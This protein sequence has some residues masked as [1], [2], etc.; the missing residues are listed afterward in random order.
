MMRVGVLQQTYSPHKVVKAQAPVQTSR[1]DWPVG[2]LF[3]QDPQRVTALLGCVMHDR[4][5]IIHKIGTDTPFMDQYQ[6]NTQ[7]LRHHIVENSEYI[8][9]QFMSQGVAEDSRSRFIH[10]ICDTAHTYQGR[11]GDEYSTLFAAANYLLEKK[12]SRLATDSRANMRYF[13]NP[14]KAQYPI[15][16]IYGKTA[17]SA[18]A[19]PALVSETFGNILFR[20]TPTDDI[21]FSPVF[22]HYLNTKQVYIAQIPPQQATWEA[23]D[24]DQVFDGFGYKKLT[25]RDAVAHYRWLT[26]RAYGEEFTTYLTRI[27][28]SSDTNDYPFQ[29]RKDLLE[30]L[31]KKYWLLGHGSLSHPSAA[32]AESDFQGVSVLTPER[33]SSPQRRPLTR[34]VNRSHQKVQ[35]LPGP[36]SHL[37]PGSLIAS[38]RRDEEGSWGEWHDGALHEEGYNSSE[39]PSRGRWLRSE[40]T[41]SRDSSTD[42]K[43]D[44][45]GRPKSSVSRPTHL[46]DAR[47]QSQ[48]EYRRLLDTS[49]DGA[50]SGSENSANR[51]GY[52]GSFSR[53]SR[54]VPPRNSLAGHRQRPAY[55]PPLRG[56]MY[57]HPD[58]HTRQDQRDTAGLWKSFQAA[59]PS[60]SRKRKPEQPPMES[61]FRYIAPSYV[62]RITY[63]EPEKSIKPR[64]YIPVIQKR[65]KD[66]AYKI[67]SFFKKL[68]FAIRM[69]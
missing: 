26:E 44:A 37:S 10:V 65:Q 9:K 1:S 63:M 18:Y 28:H 33:N 3:S 22:L 55:V 66:M 13:L 8:R 36:H 48:G 54:E 59:A 62:E 15:Q 32:V 7:A 4:N 40:S 30:E 21:V 29:A 53:D 67:G 35:A 46:E 34:P 12:T 69:R 39:N 11:T 45:K 51:V 61:K 2:D 49:S 17:S 42:S 23:L 41:S 19:E 16:T 43:H 47:S 38:D 27:G 6:K 14:A 64:Y 50:S 58:I 20:M 56:N 25:D 68:F 52:Y 24:D 60:E 57:G 31:S 5:Q